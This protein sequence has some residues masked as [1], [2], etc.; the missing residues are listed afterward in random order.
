MT[1]KGQVVHPEFRGRMVGCLLL[2]SFPF[3]KVL[4]G[5]NIYNPDHTLNFCYIDL[6]KR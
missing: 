2:M 1:V 3:R 5:N 6:N 4:F